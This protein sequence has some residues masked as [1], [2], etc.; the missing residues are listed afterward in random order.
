MGI[1]LGTSRSKSSRDN[2]YKYPDNYPYN[3]HANQQRTHS[4]LHTNGYPYSNGGY[5]T[6][7][8]QTNQLGINTNHHPYNTNSNKTIY[9]ANYDFNGTSTSGELS[10]VKG[11]QLEIID[12]YT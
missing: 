4:S 7:L 3:N 1:R 12:R 2:Q 11:D 8:I 10:F 5:G 9:I 6:H